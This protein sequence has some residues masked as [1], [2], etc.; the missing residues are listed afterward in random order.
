M[1]ILVASSADVSAGVTNSIIISN[2]TKSVI[3]IYRDG[4]PWEDPGRSPKVQQFHFPARIAPGEVMIF[5]DCASTGHEKIVVRFEVIKLSQ[6]GCLVDSFVS[7]VGSQT[8]IIGTNS[9][10][11][12]V[13]VKKK[14]LSTIRSR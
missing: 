13:V 11:V 5:T 10:Q 8:V 12:V 3:N 7:A 2:L 14:N 9:P 1:F 4:K 6:T